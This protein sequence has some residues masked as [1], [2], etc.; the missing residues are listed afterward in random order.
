[1][2]KLAK[3]QKIFTKERKQINLEKCSISV[4]GNRTL[5]P[6]CGYAKTYPYLNAKKV[7]SKAQQF[8]GTVDRYN[9]FGILFFSL[10]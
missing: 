1:M 2:Q 5:N 3:E 8:C 7:T 9:Y 4:Q 6:Q 10:H